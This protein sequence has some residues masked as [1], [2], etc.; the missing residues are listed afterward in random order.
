MTAGVEA[1]C[2]VFTT[3]PC[4]SMRKV[5]EELFGENS[6]YP[7]KARGSLTINPS[8]SLACA[9]FSWD[10]AP[11]NVVRK[12]PRA[13]A[14]VTRLTRRVSRASCRSMSGLLRES[15]DG[16]SPGIGQFGRDTVGQLAG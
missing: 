10:Q 1:P 6:V 3:R 13:A 12:R 16:P 11:S 15:G 8:L 9:A 4:M 7:W 5:F 14:S 2:Q